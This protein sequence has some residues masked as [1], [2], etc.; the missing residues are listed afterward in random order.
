MYLLAHNLEGS[1]VTVAFCGCEGLAN[2][3]LDFRYFSFPDN[4]NDI[5]TQIQCAPG[6]QKSSDGILNPNKSFF[7]NQINLTSFFT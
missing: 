5:P 3:W 4:P 6:V 1:F 2:L 7:E